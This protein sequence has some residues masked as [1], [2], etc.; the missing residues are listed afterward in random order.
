VLRHNNGWLS[1]HT[2]PMEYNVG[3]IFDSIKATREYT[4]HDSIY[5]VLKANGIYQCEFPY[6]LKCKPIFGGVATSLAD[7]I[8]GKNDIHTETSDSSIR[9][10]WTHPGEY[11]GQYYILVS[12][13]FEDYVDLKVTSTNFIDLN[14]IPYRSQNAIAYKVIS[15][16]CRESDQYLV[17]MK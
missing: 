17:I 11:T 13:L 12:N 6:L 9:I 2:V 15:E 7:M 1:R 8:H 14:L 10:E 16:E 5:N 4:T 3:S